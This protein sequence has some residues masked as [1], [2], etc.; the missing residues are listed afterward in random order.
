MLKKSSDKKIRLGIKCGDCLHYDKVCSPIHTDV[1]VNIG[2]R[3]KANAPDCFNPDFYKL[4][5]TK[6]P[7]VIQK[8]AE[9]IS[10]L[11]PSQMRVLAFTLTRGSRALE[12]HGVTF[13]QVVYFSLGAD[14]LSHYF[15]GYVIG[16][17]DEH[18]IVSSQLKKSKKNTVGQFHKSTILFKDAWRKKKDA[19]KEAGRIFMTDADKRMHMKLPLAEL[20]DSKGRVPVKIPVDFDYEPPTLDKPPREMFES[21]QKR[22]KNKKKRGL[23]PITNIEDIP[24]KRKKVRESFYFDG[25]TLDSKGNDK[26]NA[27]TKVKA[28]V[29][30]PS[31]VKKPVKKDTIKKALVKKSKPVKKVGAK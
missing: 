27:K 8:I 22:E 31:F 3:E 9:A 12:R 7:D 28:K 11:R 2:V 19:L 13:G 26:T 24:V 23:I 5:V 1:C 6:H 30:S 18:I 21:S 25:S 15:K 14:F 17:T 4:N 20:M 16:A 10:V 29:S